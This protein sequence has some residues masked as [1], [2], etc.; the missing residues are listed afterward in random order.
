MAH[1]ELTQEFISYLLADAERAV[2]AVCAPAYG[3]QTRAAVQ[4]SAWTQKKPQFA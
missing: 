4:S 1:I 3:L 2:A